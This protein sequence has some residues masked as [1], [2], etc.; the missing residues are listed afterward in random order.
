MDVGGHHK[1][2]ALCL[3]G[4]VKEKNFMLHYEFPGYATGELGR[5]GRVANLSTLKRILKNQ[6]GKNC[7]TVYQFL[8]I[9]FYQL[10]KL[11]W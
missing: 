6:K 10:I 8:L 3:L 11:L 9:I 1:S 5:G 4:G 2:N 7:L